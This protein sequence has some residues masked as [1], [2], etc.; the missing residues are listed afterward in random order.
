MNP[1]EPATPRATGSPA[2]VLIAISLSVAG[3]GLAVAFGM[4]VVAGNQHGHGW[5]S[6]VPAIVAAVIAFMALA[7]AGAVALATAGVAALV[8]LRDKG[9]FALTAGVAVAGLCFYGAARLVGW[10]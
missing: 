5:D 9:P 10:L 7:V 4:L 3:L 2:R 8:A 1:D 6:V